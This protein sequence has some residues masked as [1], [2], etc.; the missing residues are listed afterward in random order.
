MPAMPAAQLQF[1]SAGRL[2]RRIAQEQAA[3]QQGRQRQL[4]E[5]VHLA[6]AAERAQREAAQQPAQ[7]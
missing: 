6:R 1:N 2:W 7:A 5:G 3:Y 4:Q